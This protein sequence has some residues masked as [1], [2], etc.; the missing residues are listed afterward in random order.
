MK[1]TR[2]DDRQENENGEDF[3]EYKNGENVYVCT[4]TDNVMGEMDENGFVLNASR[5]RFSPEL[6]NMIDMEACEEL[7]SQKMQFSK[8]NSIVPY[9]QSQKGQNTYYP[10]RQR[11][12]ISASDKKPFV[13]NTEQ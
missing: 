6:N 10:N 4:L 5:K 8:R 11:R 2:A 7:I 12:R 3:Q 13:P 1:L 9:N